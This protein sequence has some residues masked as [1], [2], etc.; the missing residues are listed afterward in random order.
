MEKVPRNSVDCGSNDV[1]EKRDPNPMIEGGPTILVGGMEGLAIDEN[2]AL[3][4]EEWE[5][6]T[7]DEVET[8][9]VLAGV[10]N[11]V[12]TMVQMVGMVRV[13]PTEGF[14]LL[15]LSGGVTPTVGEV[16]VPTVSGLMFSTE[17][18]TVEATVEE[19]D[20]SISGGASC[21]NVGLLG[22]K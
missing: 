19:V 14:K 18:E 3:M 5:A 20:P 15:V 16:T 1:E 22:S 12:E 6:P 10:P 2:V 21:P 4:V 17:N 9:S 7:V 13:A 11:I 8:P